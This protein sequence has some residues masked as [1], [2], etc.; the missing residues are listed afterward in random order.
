LR[1][2]EGPRL[3]KERNIYQ[4]TIENWFVGARRQAEIVEPLDGK[5]DI[6]ALE[7]L[8]PPSAAT[9][10]ARPGTAANSR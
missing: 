3:E 10:R 9:F 8:W 5:V 7:A 1:T 6:K 2:Q 4:K